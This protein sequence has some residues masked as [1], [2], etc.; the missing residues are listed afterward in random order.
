[1]KQLLLI[2]LLQA[3]VSLAISQ[4]KVPIRF[5]ESTDIHKAK[6]KHNKKYKIELQ[7]INRFIYTVGSE[8]SEK[9]FHTE[10]P[11]ILKGIKLPGFLTLSLPSATAIQ[12]FGVDGNEAGSK[13][14]SDKFNAYCA[15]I[16]EKSRKLNDAAYLSREVNIA[17]S[18]CKDSFSTISEKLLKTINTYTG[19]SDPDLST[20]T[21]TLVNLIRQNRDSAEYFN[22]LLA[23]LGA[24]LS[25]EIEEY[26]L[27]GKSAILS[28]EIA[29][30]NEK[31][32]CKTPC[33]VSDSLKTLYS[34]LLAAKEF[35]AMLE[36]KSEEIASNLKEAEEAIDAMKAFEKTGELEKLADG[37][38]SVNVH[39][40]SYSTEVFT[41]KKD[42]I[43]FKITAA[44]EKPLS[45]NLPQT[46]I[47]T[48]KGRTYQGW[49]LDFS[50]GVF[51]NMGNSDFKGAGFSYK[52]INDDSSM[53]RRIDGGKSILL[54]VGG[55]LHL[56][57]LQDAF[58]KP[59]ISIG[60]SSSSGFDILNLHAGL[61][62]ILGDKQRFIISGG[63][64]LRESKMLDR[65]YQLNKMYKTDYLPDEPP[66]T[67]V[68]PKAGGF[69][70]LTY[71]ITRG[72]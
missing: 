44:A 18:N 20:A 67:T 68:F 65:E 64:T 46:R 42:E 9:N 56:Y 58:I 40:F 17:T 69:F 14:E 47:I 63:L 66:V 36:N 38:L 7:N 39:N 33:P 2:V 37:I 6:F 8:K 22:G 61:S 50:T 23:K 35:A 49:R 25:S 29:I 5:N 11:E 62:I 28:I 4:E 71:N 60:V 16:K 12:K 21:S 24:S 1:M 15:A 55:L 51:L 45:C 72:E 31:A 41:A 52:K 19:K 27:T 10:T 3:T 70:S 32:K 53:I 26:I 13:T 54:S 30:Q 59:G 57:Y 34:E 43:I 48:V